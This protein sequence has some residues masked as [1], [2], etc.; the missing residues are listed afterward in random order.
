MYRS[1]PEVRVASDLPMLEGLK[2]ES[3]RVHGHRCGQLHT[4]AA[5]GLFKSKIA[6]LKCAKGMFTDW[7]VRVQGRTAAPWFLKWVCLKIPYLYINLLVN[8]V[9]P[10]FSLVFSGCSH[11]FPFFYGHGFSPF[12]DHFRPNNG[13]RL[14]S[15]C[16]SP[17]SCRWSPPQKSD[18]SIALTNN[19]EKPEICTKMQV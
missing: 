18:G 13:A 8:H 15:W 16:D 11:V 6:L 2:R 5:V 9:V 19:L 12:S 7:W 1:L 4:R 17:R 14:L 10:W 3:R